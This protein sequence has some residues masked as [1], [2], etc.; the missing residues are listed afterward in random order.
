VR[1]P[2]Q[3]TLQVA[4][5]QPASDP[6][7]PQLRQHA[8]PRRSLFRRPSLRPRAD[9]FLNDQVFDPDDFQ[10]DKLLIRGSRG[11]EV[12]SNGQRIGL[13]SQSALHGVDDVNP[14]LKFGMPQP[15]VGNFEPSS[16]TEAGSEQLSDQRPRLC[17]E[18]LDATGRP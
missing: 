7:P 6:V 3:T 17:G 2:S 10:R 9:N 12:E 15:S 8:R 16:P 18:H 4:G 14:D 11:A 5:T 1:L 13:L